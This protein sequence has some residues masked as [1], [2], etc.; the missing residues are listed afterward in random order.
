MILMMLVITGAVTVVIS[1]VALIFFAYRKFCIRNR[2]RRRDTYKSKTRPKTLTFVP[3]QFA[4][5]GR[6]HIN[7][8]N[9]DVQ[10]RVDSVRTIVNTPTSMSPCHSAV[11]LPRSSSAVGLPYDG[12][13]YSNAPDQPDTSYIDV[14]ERK[15]SELQGCSHSSVQNDMDLYENAPV[16]ET[17]DSEELY[18]N[19]PEGNEYPPEANV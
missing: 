9:G 19:Y 11:V 14:R 17:P 5:G 4:P 12:E 8:Q 6:N 3:N 10:R 16:A 15:E 7:I 1:I 2:F 18:P 13:L